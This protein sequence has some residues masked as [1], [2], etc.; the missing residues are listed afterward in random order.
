MSFLDIFR[1][2]KTGDA[3]PETVAGVQEIL[4]SLRRERGLAQAEL[5]SLHEAREA[6]LVDAESDSEIFALDQRMDAISLTIERL[7]AAEPGLLARL[8]A[9]SGAARR[10]R[11]AALV[12]RYEPAEALY[13]ET[14]AAA[15]TALEKL[16][17]LRLEMATE[18]RDETCEFAYPP[19]RINADL[20]D[21]FRFTIEQR[22]DVA[23]K[24]LDAGKPRPAP[25]AAVQAAPPP[26]P[27]NATAAQPPRRFL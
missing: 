3:A 23:Q 15:I 2:R 9:A 10:A 22:H 24:R 18:F 14:M 19:D 6:L 13:C 7:D 16:Q 4:A 20:L 25:A 8:D 1:N 21:R 5:H 26:K 12:A 17:K 11:L 27:A